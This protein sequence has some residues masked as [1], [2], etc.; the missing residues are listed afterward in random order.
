MML[1]DLSPSGQHRFLATDIDQTIL[2][3]ARAGG[4]YKMREMK[5][6]DK[7]GMRKYFEQPNASVDEHWVV[8]ELRR[9]VEFRCHNLMQ[10]TFEGSFDLIVCRNV[11]IYFGNEARDVL[12]RRFHRSLNHGGVLFTGGS[13]VILGA[14]DLGFESLHQCFYRKDNSG[15]VVARS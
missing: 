5:N 13:E 6:I 15:A 3:H 8:D 11:V 14:K 1:S 4:P 2:N 10:D 9:K 12:Y 7:W